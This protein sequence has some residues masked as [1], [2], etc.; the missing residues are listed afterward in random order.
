MVTRKELEEITRKQKKK[1]PIYSKKESDIR[2]AEYQMFYLNNLDIF[3]EEFLEIKLYHFQRQML[4]DIWINDVYFADASRG[5]SKSLTGGAFMGVSLA[6][7]LPGIEIIV[8]SKTLNQA[9]KIIE[10][11]IKNLL[12]DEANG[13]SE[14]TKQL[15]RDKYIKFGKVDSTEASLVTFGNGSTIT[16]VQCAKGGRGSRG[17]V[18]IVD[19]CALLEK[20][21]YDSIIS[22]TLQPYKKNGLVLETKQIFMTSSRYKTNWCWNYLKECVNG[23]YKK[24]SQIKYGFFFA[25]IFTAVASGIQTKK[26]LI[27]RRKDIDPLDFEMEFLNM[28]IGEGEDSAF[29]LQEFQNNQCLEIPFI[30]LSNEEYFDKVEQKHNFYDNDTR[31]IAMDIAIV[32]G[33]KNDNT[34]FT[35]GAIDDSGILKKR[36]ERTE[37]HSG[38][39]VQ[40][41]VVL[42]KRLFYE[43]KAHFFIMDTKGVGVTMYDLFL[44]ET[45]DE[46]R[47]ITYPAWNLC[48][49]RKLQIASETVLSEKRERFNILNPNIREEDVDRVIIPFTGN[50]TLNSDICKSLRIALRNQD[51]SFLKD[52][53]D[54]ENK[55]DMENPNYTTLSAE[56][57]VKMKM[58]FLE[59]RFMINESI[60]LSAEIK[61]NEI[62]VKE[63]SKSTKDRYVSLAMLNY[64]LDKAHARYGNSIENEFDEEDWED[65]LI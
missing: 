37:A 14:I 15:Y 25:D 5:I 43:Y 55:W 7:L 29:T 44:Q 39:L 51:I 19:E 62:K 40:K 48:S 11:K 1:K 57:K 61:G 9:N 22:P 64:F 30:P 3:V 18:V 26:Q 33:R 59:T 34:C 63:D 16:S 47:D 24:G 49:D 31:A 50:P 12:C 46:D 53:T 32:G 58:P 23:H 65:A 4:L 52:E 27:Q 36:V 10:N 2:C 42:A 13:L 6:L 35:L 21:D 56:E 45:Y 54:M 38:M 60:T 17:N 20:K 8:T 41:Q 28:W